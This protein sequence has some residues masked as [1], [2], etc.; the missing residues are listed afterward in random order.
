MKYLDE[1]EFFFT[2]IVFEVSISHICS[3]REKREGEFFCFFVF[4]PD[5]GQL[6]VLQGGSMI[7]LMYVFWGFSLREQRKNKGGYSGCQ[8]DLCCL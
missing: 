3:I 5:P 4:F 7:A 2:V 6:Q 8:L 1:E